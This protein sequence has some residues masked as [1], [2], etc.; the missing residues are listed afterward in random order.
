MSDTANTQ[1]LVTAM[2]QDKRFFGLIKSDIEKAAAAFGVIARKVFKEDLTPES[3][4]EAERGAI[5][6]EAGIQPGEEERR[7]ADIAGI[8]FDGISPEPRKQEDAAHE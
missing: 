3:L 6:A 2:L 7:I 8:F 5:M 1:I 4:T